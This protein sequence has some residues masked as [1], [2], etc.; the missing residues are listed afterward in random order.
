MKFRTVI[1]LLPYPFRID[2]SHKIF[3]LGSCFVD[4]MKQ[5][6]D[7]YQFQ[8]QI[9]PF[10][11]IFNPVSIK[12]TLETIVEKR[13]FTKDDLFYHQDTWKS[14]QLHSVF[15]CTDSSKLL[16]EVNEKIQTAHRFLAQSNHLLITLGTAW[17]YRLKSNGEIVSNCHKVPQKEFSKELLSTTEIAG[18]LNKIISLAKSLSQDINILFTVSPVRHL[19]DGFVE[20]NVSKSRLLDAVY[21]VVNEQN[22]F[23]F[24]SY[25]IMMDDLRDYRFYKPD[26]IHPNQTAVDYIWLKL[27]Q[28]LMDDKTRSTMQQVEKIRKALQHKAFNPASKEHQAFLEKINRQI[29]ALQKRFD[30][31]QF[32]S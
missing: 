31:M 7:F 19:K 25:E 28:A 22:A 14:Y 5:K 13:Y 32:E 27:Q 23:Y 10:G 6:F 30:W 20:N 9:N 26:M 29:Q 24:P 3:G 21:Q 8:S 12:N 11:V 2:Y 16:H 18:N 15:N 17:V 4:H 1:S